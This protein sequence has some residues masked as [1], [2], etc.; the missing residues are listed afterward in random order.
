MPYTDINTSLDDL[1]APFTIPEG[2][3][4]T[5]FDYDTSG[6]K[7][8]WAQ[9]ET[10]KKLMSQQLQ[11]MN[12]STASTG[13]GFSGM[14]ARTQVQDTTSQMFNEKFGGMLDNSMYQEYK[15][16]KDWKEEQIGTIA[17][18]I[19]AGDVTTSGDTGDTETIDYFNCGDGTFAPTEEDCGNYDEGE[20][21]EPSYNLLG[22]CVSCC[23]G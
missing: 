13:K 17:D 9:F 14:G 4:N 7:N 19:I 8:V 23:D 2:I 10:D 22:Q 20:G 21:C 15:L 5:L 1:T 16:K 3:R 11:Q 18:S 12:T 6:Q